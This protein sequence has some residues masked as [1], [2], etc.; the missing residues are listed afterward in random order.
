VRSNEDRKRD[1]EGARAYREAHWDNNGINEELDEEQGT[2][3][4]GGTGREQTWKDDRVR[5][6][7]AGCT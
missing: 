1:K 4:E 3:N 2:A 6:Q 7:I 5:R